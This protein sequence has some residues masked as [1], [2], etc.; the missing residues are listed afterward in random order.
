MYHGSR[1]EQWGHTANLMALLANC[2]RDGKRRRRPFDLA[3]F[4]PADLKPL[5]RRSSG[6]RLTASN[7]HVLKPL[8]QKKA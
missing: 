1:R 4:L 3:D 6:F 8:F 5:V 7:L 2:H